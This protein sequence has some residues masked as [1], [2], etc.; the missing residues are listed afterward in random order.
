MEKEN[1]I[2]NLDLPAKE[3]WLFLEKYK[4][5]IEDLIEYYLADLS[6]AEFLFDE[7]D[8]YKN[9]IITTEYLEEISSLASFTKFTENEIL[10]ANL[11]Y[12]V[13]KFYFGCTAF[14]VENNGTIFHSRNLDWHTE[15]DLLSKHSRVFDF[16]KNGKTVFKSV[17]WVGFIGVLSGNKP[18]QFSITLNAVLSN[19]SPEIAQPITFLLRDVL[20]NC[21][22]F[23]E[24]EEILKNTTIICDCLLLLSGTKSDEKIVIERTPKRAEIRKPEKNHIVVT[25]DYKKLENTNF[26]QN[27]LQ[28]TS[29][30]RF[31][32][33]D[34]LLNQ[35]NPEN[36]EDC[37]SILKNPE[38][39]MGITVQQ[40]VFNNNTGE[41][42]FE[43]V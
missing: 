27:L 35:K 13:L 3:R 6:E 40:M 36:L 29:C 10:I 41:I 26:S 7:I 33:T 20:T 21:N 37:I 15:N 30:G 32:K 39:Q 14:A 31:N 4:K 34:E 5:E 8:S 23:S 9:S 2:I 16:Q 43:K 38:I 17:G 11:Y 42:L 25:N 24:A 18:N 19:D 12:D 22:S 28:E 1:L